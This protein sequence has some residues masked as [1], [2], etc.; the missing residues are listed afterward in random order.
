MVRNEEQRA[1][2]LESDSRHRRE[3]SEV[4]QAR[5]R[6]DAL[7]ETIVASFD[8]ALSDTS[9]LVSLLLNLVGGDVHLIYAMPGSLGAG[10]DEPGDMDWHSDQVNEALVALSIRA[11]QQSVDS[12]PDDWLEL[13]RLFEH[14]SESLRLRAFEMCADRAESYEIAEFAMEALIGH[15]RANQ[16]RLTGRTTELL[17]ASHQ[18]GVGGVYTSFP[19]VSAKLMEAIRR[20]LTPAHKEFIQSLA[21]HELAPIRALSARWSG[22]LGKRA[23]AG[24]L[25]SLLDDEDPLV[26][27]AAVGAIL[28]LDPAMLEK[29]IHATCDR[30]GESQEASVLRRMLP[31]EPSWAV[32]MGRR[33]EAPWLPEYLSGE[34]L[35]V[36]LSSVGHRRRSSDD[37]EEAPTRSPFSEFPSWVERVVSGWPKKLDEETIAL[38]GMWARDARQSVHLVGRR[39]MAEYGS[40]NEELIEELLNSGDADEIFSGAECAVMVG[41]ERFV[42]PVLAVLRGSLDSCPSAEDI[43]AAGY[44]IREDDWAYKHQI[45]MT[46]ASRR[47][48]LRQALSHTTSGFAPALPFIAKSIPYD[49]TEGF[50][51]IEGD[52]IIEVITNLIR[53]WGP[54]AVAILDLIEE[55][56]IEDVIIFRLA[57][58]Q[59]AREHSE[60][61]KS[62]EDRV[63]RGSSI[64]LDLLEWVRREDYKHDLEGLAQILREEVFSD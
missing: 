11:L 36:V 22:E 12:H 55:G 40:V 18:A 44:E 46:Q 4:K 35:R 43:R 31:R 48:R 6:R 62:L 17:L 16:T 59:V 26:V 21:K 8:T 38:F 49:P 3:S 45:D 53:R 30:W 52:L 23:W 9:A 39:L 19:N 32:L 15:V 63:A 37:V 1:N 64:A 56:E 60:F 47:E 34:T 33:G 58:Q 10:F 54:D 50:Y 28:S 14:P 2:E 5:E 20:R 51:E 13:K 25:E 7:A 29:W 42:E 41:L 27:D 57:L 61:I 24:W